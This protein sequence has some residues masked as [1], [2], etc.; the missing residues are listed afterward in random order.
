M[1][2]FESEKTPQRHTYIYIYVYG[3][4]YGKRQRCFFSASSP[5]VPLNSH[6]ARVVSWE[7]LN[8]SSG[9]ASHPNPSFPTNPVAVLRTLIFPISPCAC[10]FKRESGAWDGSL[11][12]CDTLRHMHA[13]KGIF[14]HKTGPV[15]ILWTKNISMDRWKRMQL[16]ENKFFLKDK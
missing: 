9:R 7:D 10:C 1:A 5:G 6:E 15:S 14:E 4:V 3:S 16:F 8:R 13:D 12:A 11:N 2:S